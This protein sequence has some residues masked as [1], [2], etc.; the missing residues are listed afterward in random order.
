MNNNLDKLLENQKTWLLIKILAFITFLIT[1]INLFLQSQSKSLDEDEIEHAHVAW[2]LFKNKA[3]Y[4]DFFEHHPPHYWYILSTYYHISGENTAVFIFGR[5]LMLITFSLAVIFLYLIGKE[6]FG[7]IGGLITAIILCLNQFFQLAGIA[8]RP[9]GVMVALLLAGTYFFIR[10][11]KN[12]FL[13]YEALLSGLLLGLAFAL[14]P[15]SG[16]TILALAIA[17][18]IGWSSKNGI[19]EI[20]SRKNNLL[21]FAV[22]A[23]IPILLPFLIYGFSFYLENMYRV[24]SSIALPFFNPWDRLRDIFVKTFALFPLFFISLPICV[25]LIFKDRKLFWLNGLTFLFSFLNLFALFMGMIFLSRPEIYK[26]LDF[27][28]P[29]HNFYVLIPSLALSTA[30]GLVWLL[31]QVPSKKQVFV[32]IIFFLLAIVSSLR[33][34]WYITN[35]LSRNLE[36]IENLN[37]IIPKNETFVGNTISNPIFRMDGTFH[38]VDVNLKLM[39]E[40]LPNFHYDFVSE[41]KKTH[42]YIVNKN[43]LQRL[44]HDPTH[45]EQ[46]KK[47]LEENYQPLKDFPNLLIRNNKELLNQ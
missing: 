43:F 40:I 5:I 15:R 23:F 7:K 2:L 4:I 42:P 12:K 18:L 1:F 44:E 19:K 27:I 38:W 11:W 22:T 41:F 46:T 30:Q 31:N 35:G 24:S 10:G 36:Y 37:K 3:L 20:L 14:H 45:L 32:L 8:M 6:I 17:V 28:P 16:F 29:I 9:D 33:S 39:K 13:F 34:D 25:Y 26:D 47:Y 21:I